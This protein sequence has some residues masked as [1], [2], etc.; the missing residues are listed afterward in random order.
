[1]NV[2]DLFFAL[3]MAYADEPGVS[4]PGES[5]GRGFG[6][7]ALKVNGSIFAMVT[8]E[9]LV[10]KLPRGRVTSLIESGEG[11]PFDAGKGRPMKE[12][13]TVEVQ[14]EQTWLTLS[15]EAMTFVRS[16]RS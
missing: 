1:M 2:D 13:L 16:L 6:S 14:S 12:W 5:G 8:R 11:S 3:V 15:R 10:V 4:V 7:T 9:H